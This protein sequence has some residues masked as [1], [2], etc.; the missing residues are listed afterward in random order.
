MFADK[1]LENLYDGREKI[2]SANQVDNLL[3]MM[4]GN[5]VTITDD[6]IFCCQELISES[7]YNHLLRKLSDEKVKI[8]CSNIKQVA[9]FFSMLIGL[10]FYLPK[11]ITSQ[12]K[13]ALN[14][15]QY[16]IFHHGMHIF[17]S[18]SL[19]QRRRLQN[20][21]PAKRHKWLSDQLK[22]KIENEKVKKEIERKRREEEF[23]ERLKTQQEKLRLEHIKKIR[24]RNAK[25][26]KLVNLN[27]PGHSIWSSNIILTNMGG[28]R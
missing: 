14:P 15:Q 10:E 11:E 7:N 16:H 18:L 20:Y 28:K 1:V 9:S 27:A 6:F 13:R 12:V 25:R 8:G 17:Y 19:V 5:N 21:A 2:E 4:W 3:I 26:A 23:N 22:S 24:D